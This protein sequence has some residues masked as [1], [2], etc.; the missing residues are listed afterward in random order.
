MGVRLPLVAWKRAIRSSALPRNSFRTGDVFFL[1]YPIASSTVGGS[2]VSTRGLGISPP[3]GHGCLCDLCACGP[4][5]A[6]GGGVAVGLRRATILILVVEGD[7]TLGWDELDPVLA[8]V[9]VDER[10]F[11]A[12]ARP[13]D[14]VQVDHEQAVEAPFRGVVEELLERRAGFDGL[15]RLAV[16]LVDVDDVPALPLRMLG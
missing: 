12:L 14:A 13:R 5:R 7:E 3:D 11:R 8:K 4:R 10:S 2:P 9:V 1:L 6:L 15:P 16:V